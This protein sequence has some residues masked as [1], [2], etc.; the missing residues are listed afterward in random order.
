MPDEYEGLLA[1]HYDALYAV[2]RDP[3]GDAAFYRALAQEIG[4]PV[5]E[6]GCGTGRVLLPIAALGIPCVGLD[7]SPAMLAVLRAKNPPPNV[8]L[9]EAR[10]EAFD[11]GARKFPLVTCP[12]RAFQHLLTV[13]A[14][15]AALANVRR[16]LAPG[17]AFALD[18]FDP[19]LAWLTA[20]GGAER[21][22]ATFTIGGVQTRRFVRTRVDLATQTFEIT[23]RFDPAPANADGSTTVRLRWFYRYEIEHLLARAGFTDITVFGGYDRRPWCPEADTVLVA[24]VA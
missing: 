14:Q 17:G 19:K 5:L 18:V 15:L 12:F 13:D 20:P 2:M 24:R 3:S 1:P 11:L 16:H 22:D 6:L 21:M 7:A 10:M 8:E 23:F 4:G 9:V